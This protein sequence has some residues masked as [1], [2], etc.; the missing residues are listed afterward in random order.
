MFVRKIMHCVHKLRFKR[1]VGILVCLHLLLPVT[2]QK[3]PRI[4]FLPLPQS[5]RFESEVG[6]GNLSKGGRW[7]LEI[8][9]HSILYEYKFADVQRMSYPTTSLFRTQ[10]QATVLVRWPLSGD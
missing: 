8:I 1:K 3:Q 4:C 9:I 7:L 6:L 5:I 10:I 2:W